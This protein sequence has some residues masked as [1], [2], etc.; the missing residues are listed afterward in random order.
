MKIRYS[1]ESVI[2]PTDAVAILEWAACHIEH[3]G[4]HQGRGL[5][6]GP[7]RT[8]TLPCWPRGAIEIA[9]GKSRITTGRTYDWTRI[10]EARAEAFRLIAEHLVDG[11]LD[12]DNEADTTQL[13]HE[14]LDEWSAVTGRTA[15]DAARAF[16]AAAT[17]A[18][19]HLF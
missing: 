18:E 14:V 9:A 19:N 17:H 15:A 10:R 7:G 6:A 16:R 11:C 5:F 8:V 13:H 3:V 12:L 2:V 1:P 4:I